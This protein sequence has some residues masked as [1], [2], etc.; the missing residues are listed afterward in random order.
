MLS[1]ENG[2][3]K[4]RKILL[5][6]NFS[7]DHGGGATPVPIPNTAVKPLSGDGTAGH[8]PWESSTLPGF[9]KRPMG[10]P[11]GR[12]I[13][14]QRVRSAREDPALPVTLCLM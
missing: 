12:F 11:I 3:R 14:R 1:Q 8:H 4:W 10:K 13:F 2:I 7:G 9:T 6:Q 5:S